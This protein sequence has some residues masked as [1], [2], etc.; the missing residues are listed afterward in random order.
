M[1]LLS[2]EIVG[3]STTHAAL[4]PALDQTRPQFRQLT[5]R[6]K[7]NNAAHASERLLDGIGIADIFGGRLPEIEVPNGLV[8]ALEVSAYV[9]PDKA[10]RP[11]DQNHPIPIDALPVGRSVCCVVVAI[12]AFSGSSEFAGASSHRRAPAIRK[13]VR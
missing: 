7:V 3:I 6:R 9:P 11:R 13:D 10:A 8:C 1:I 12:S 2:P 4:L 5:D